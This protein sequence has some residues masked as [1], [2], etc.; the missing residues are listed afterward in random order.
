[1]LCSRFDIMT[2]YCSP[3][4]HNLLGSSLSIPT[5]SLRSIQDLSFGLGSVIWLLKHPPDRG[6]FFSSQMST[7]EKPMFF[8]RHLMP[9]SSSIQTSS[10]IS[11]LSVVL[12]I[13]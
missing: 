2:S 5:C 7:E 1:M 10:F 8:S 6:R 12:R 4:V 3:R 11:Q 13:Q 9:F